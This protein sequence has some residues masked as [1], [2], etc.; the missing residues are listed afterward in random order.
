MLVGD[1]TALVL[2]LAREIGTPAG[3]EATEYARLGCAITSGQPIDP[4]QDEAPDLYDPGGC[5]E[6]FD[7]WSELS[8]QFQPT[9][10]VVMIGAWEVLDHVADGQRFSFPSVEWTAHV[11]TAIRRAVVAASA[12]GGRVMFLRL[13]CMVQSTDSLVSVQARNDPDRV[14]AFNAILETVAGELP[15]VS[16]LR[17]DDLLCPGGVPI[18]EVDG[19]S[20]RFDGVH[21]TGAGTSLVWTWLEERL[22]ESQ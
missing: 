10:S 7:D 20:I 22:Q 19:E 6:W 15:Q 13:P 9:T 4:G 8:R 3:W 17:L 12:G 1:S 14:A 2:A 5:A 11:E 16:T 18:G 21:L